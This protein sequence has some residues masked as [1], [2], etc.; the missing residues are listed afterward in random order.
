M[1]AVIA[2]H[3][4]VS[5]CFLCRFQGVKREELIGIT[6]NRLIRMDAGTGDAIKTWRFSNMKQWN[7]NWEIKMVR[8]ALNIKLLTLNFCCF[9]SSPP[10]PLPYV[11]SFTSRLITS[12]ISITDLSAGDTCF[13][14]IQHLF[15]VR[16]HP[17]IL[18]SNPII[19]CF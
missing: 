6:Y 9:S 8:N 10:H 7:V 17:Q 14:F 13:L 5:A 16:S 3:F 18:F 12:S 15:P 2:V 11:T 1:Q 19:I 4:M